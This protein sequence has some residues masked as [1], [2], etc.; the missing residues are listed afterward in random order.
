MMF[1]GSWVGGSLMAL[2]K[3]V[4]NSI[5]NERKLFLLLWIGTGT[6]AASNMFLRF[7][8]W[9]MKEEINLICNVIIPA[10]TKLSAIS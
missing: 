2:R 7:N 3:N 5:G 1:V 6:F 8:L 10:R 4:I 9:K